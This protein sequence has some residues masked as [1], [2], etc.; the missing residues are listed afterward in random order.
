[1]DEIAAL[2]LVATLTTAFVGAIKKAF[3]K[4]TDGK[5]ELLALALPMIV[6]VVF[7]TTHV[8]DL[9]WARVV[10]DA[11]GGGLL[12]GV[13]HDKIVNPIMAGKNGNGGGDS[14]AGGGK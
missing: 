6:F 14:A 2:A 10:I 5:E 1:M 11:V 7:K 9:T 3:P 8:V 12:A 4:W 13:A